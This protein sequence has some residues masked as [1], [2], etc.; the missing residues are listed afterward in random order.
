MERR[1][2]PNR[3]DCCLYDRDLFLK[4]DLDPFSLIPRLVRART[5]NTLIDYTSKLD[6]I[7]SITLS[8]SLCFPFLLPSSFVTTS[9]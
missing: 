9:R 7:R 8:L 6:V 5:E 2:I 4:F 3:R 1:I